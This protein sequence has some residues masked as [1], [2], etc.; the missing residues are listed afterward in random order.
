MAALTG[1]ASNASQL[2]SQSAAYYLGRA[3]H[4]GTL[5]DTDVDFWVEVS[6]PGGTLGSRKARLTVLEVAPA[7]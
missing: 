7:E 4:T 2:N 5:A 1:T 3:N 6:G